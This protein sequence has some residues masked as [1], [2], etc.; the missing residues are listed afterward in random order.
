[1]GNASLRGAR[2]MLRS[3]S[4]RAS[5]DALVRRIE[6]VELETHPEFFDFFV[7]GCRF[8]PMDI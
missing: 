1:M 4:R 6:H 5:V 7:E 3:G 2:I 8:V